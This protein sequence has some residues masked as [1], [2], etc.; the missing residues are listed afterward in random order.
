VTVVLGVSAGL[1]T[2]LGLPVPALDLG[3]GRQS[4]A[5]SASVFGIDAGT[6]LG[7]SPGYVFPL[8]GPHDFGDGG[9]RFGAS[10]YGHVH[11][12]QDVFGKVGTTEVA[13]HD[14]V[15][16]DRGKDGDR[17]SG[18]RGNYLAIY[19]PPDNHSFVYMH[20]LKPSPVQLGDPVHAGQVVGQLGCSGSCDGPHLHF[21]VRIGKAT[22]R[23]GTKP[24][25]PLP[26]L[27]QWPQATPG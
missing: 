4:L 10:R 8:I 19:S 26:F 24:V 20:M 9:A 14:G 11:E 27:R 16:V 1:G 23:S 5:N 13:V 6:P 21:E 15:V 7:L 25:D 17:Y 3:A 2:L 18:G 12:G 22:S